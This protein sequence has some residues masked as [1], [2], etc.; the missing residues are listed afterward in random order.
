MSQTR[1]KEKTLSPGQLVTRLLWPPPYAREESC[2]GLHRCV[3]SSRFSFLIL[4]FPV[5]CLPQ[6]YRKWGFWDYTE[7]RRMLKVR[8]R[9]PR[10]FAYSSPYQPFPRTEEC[11]IS[12][13]LSPRP[14]LLLCHSPLVGRLH[15]GHLCLLGWYSVG[16]FPSCRRLGKQILIFTFYFCNKKQV[17]PNWGIPP[18]RCR[19]VLGGKGRGK[20]WEEPPKTNKSGTQ[21]YFSGPCQEQLCH[22]TKGRGLGLRNRISIELDTA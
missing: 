15:P 22:R 9:M 3:T 1:S 18:N 12:T 4:H 5:F 7:V 19:Q 2:Q 16:V 6:Y 21:I 20:G 13:V 8:G 11:H 14:G 17:L 10:S